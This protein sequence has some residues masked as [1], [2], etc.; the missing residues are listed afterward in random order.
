MFI[1]D[2]VHSGALKLK[3]IQGFEKLR[4]A[5]KENP[6]INFYV[7][8]PFEDLLGIIAL[9]SHRN[10]CVVII[11][12]SDEISQ[13]AKELLNN[14]GFLYESNFE[15]NE[16]KEENLPSFFESIA[17]SQE[18][19]TK[20]TE[21]QRRIEIERRPAAVYRL[22]F[23]KNF[24]FVDAL[25]IVPYLKDL[26]ISHCYSSPILCARQGS[27]HGYDIIN[28]SVL[29]PEIG[30]MQEF[31]DF[32]NTLH[33]YDMGLIIDIVPNHMGLGKEN[34]WWMDVLENGQASKYASYFDIDWEPVKTELKGKILV[35]VL[36]DH[37][38]NIIASGQFKFDIDTETGK[39]KLNYWDHE[40]PI[41]PSSY[42]IFLEHRIEVLKSRLG[43]NNPDFLEYLSIITE[44]KNLP[45]IN[46]TSPE[47]IAERNREKDI[48]SKRGAVL[49]RKNPAC[50]GFIQE[51]LVD[52]EGKPNDSISCNRIHN[53]LEEQAYRDAYW[54]VSIDVINYR[55]FFDVN[56]LIGLKTENP[57]VFTNTHSLILELIEQEKIDGL[58]I[59]HPDGLLD[60]T[61]YFKTLQTEAGK[62]LDI[63]FDDSEE[64]LLG[65]E[66][67]P[68]FVVA[69]K[70]L[71][72]FEKTTKNWAINGTVGYEFLNEVCNLFI[73]PKNSQKFT[74][75]YQ[76]FIGN[77]IN[78]NELVIECKKL[79]MKTSLTGELSTLA[80]Y[81]NRISEKYYSTRDYTLNGFRE[82]L[83]EIIA[84]FPVYRT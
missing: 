62:K 82:A 80:N 31:Y 4:W 36:G 30:T 50:A 10:K 13:S 54:R 26:G 45:E 66:K 37:Y 15:I 55:R 16:I 2:M 9:E 83:S 76:R 69:E 22:Q 12:E 77:T 25:N 72:P 58:R 73:E 61:G 20:G 46:E 56:D 59:D 65:S 35:P 74:K 81:L 33:Y 28:H 51:N 32:V 44:F 7:K 43:D 34:L 14:Y 40:F 18:Q 11:N 42:P 29:N 52:F 79:I 24:T 71:A 63:N 68:I 48:A 23:N 21:Y 38:G 84:C 27:N 53:L 67:L 39:L 64:D 17:L 57:L 1:P 8:Y 70:I 49:F 60:P 6:E 19:K 47:K 5:V 75:I 78:F 41:N 3:N